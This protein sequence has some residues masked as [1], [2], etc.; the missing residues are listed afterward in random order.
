MLNVYQPTNLLHTGIALVFYLLMAGFVV[1]SFLAL[2]ALNRFG[3]SK[4]LATVISLIYIVIIASLF[5]AAQT[6][7]NS[8]KF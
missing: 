8:I 5:A 7:L 1:Y 3:H 6:N 4:L 2:Y